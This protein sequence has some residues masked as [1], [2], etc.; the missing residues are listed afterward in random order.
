MKCFFI[1]ICILL[2]VMENDGKFSN[3]ECKDSE[4]EQNGCKCAYDDSQEYIIMVCQTI[5]E[6][7]LNRI[8]PITGKVIRVVNSYDRWPIIPEETKTAFALILSENQ[9]DSIGDLK[10]LDTLQYFNMSHNQLKKIDSSISTLTNLY[11]LDLSFNLFEEFHF[12]DLVP[13]SDT[14]TFDSRPIFSALRYL[15]LNG[16]RIKQIYNFD[17]AFVAMPICNIITLDILACDI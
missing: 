3:I 9:I 16:N 2:N 5:L 12:E 10:N 7:S 14:N 15:I 8:P 6:P 11:L 13:N 4:L 17:L 1:F